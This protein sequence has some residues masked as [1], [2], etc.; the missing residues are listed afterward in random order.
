[1]LATVK[2]NFGFSPSR[3]NS[4]QIGN[5]HMPVFRSV[6]ARQIDAANSTSPILANAIFSKQNF[7]SPAPNAKPVMNLDI[8]VAAMRAHM[9]GQS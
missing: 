2:T 7:F 5:G 9:A 6:R 1:M 8:A 3:T 4:A